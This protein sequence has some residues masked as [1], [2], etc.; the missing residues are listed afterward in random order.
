MKIEELLYKLTEI[1]ISLSRERDINT[2]LEK[3]LTEARTFT[4]AEG[5]SLYIKEGDLLRFILSQNDVL[6][7]NKK[8]IFVNE[9]LQLSSNS[10]AGYVGITGKTLNIENVH[11]LPYD[12]PY[13]YNPKFDEENNYKT[14][15]M[16]LA[17]MKDGDEVIGVLALINAR[18]F[19]NKVIPFDSRYESLLNS[20]ASQAA[21]AYLN[22]QLTKKLKDAYLETVL[23]LSMAAECREPDIAGHLSR[24]STYSAILAEELGFS[25]EEVEN[26]ECASPMHDVGKIG[27]PDSILLKPA[28]LTKEEYEEMKKHTTYGANILRG[29]SA[30][31]LRLSEKIALTHH[32]CF[33]GSGYPE[34]LSGESI[35]IEGR[36]VA[37]ADV[38][39]ALT[40]KRVYKDS[41]NTEEVIKYIHEK[42]GTQFDPKVVEALD[43]RLEDFI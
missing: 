28:K 21:V 3:I 30:D 38:F 33:D 14:E 6:V 16:L 32:E 42:S 41:W 29:S 37:L 24:I 40:S 17:P 43:K 8:T 35:P 10:M 13:K 22:A 4:N 18:S 34:G 23:R 39:D 31:I 1:G 2:L 15:S 20:L 9:T 27:V 25:R 11:N 36:I 26:I 5:G 12:S 19:E 7:K